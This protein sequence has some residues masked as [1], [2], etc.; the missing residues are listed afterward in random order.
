MFSCCWF[1]C[2]SSW[3]WLD[4]RKMVFSFWI[5][6]SRTL[7]VPESFLFVSTLDGTMHAVKKQTGEIRWSLKEGEKSRD[8][9]R[10]YLFLLRKSWSFVLT[11]NRFKR[12]VVF[13]AVLLFWKISVF[14]KGKKNIVREFCDYLVISRDEHCVVQ[15]RTAATIWLHHHVLRVWS[16]FRCFSYLISFPRG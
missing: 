12:E 4:S 7:S 8:L 13:W 16:I 14:E 1:H 6:Q 9:S 11:R 15:Y 3:I 2:F 5:L 10:L